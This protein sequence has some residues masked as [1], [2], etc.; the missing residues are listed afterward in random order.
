MLFRSAPVHLTSCRS[1]LW[2][3]SILSCSSSQERITRW[4]DQCEGDVGEVRTSVAEALPPR[5]NY[6]FGTR[7]VLNR[8]RSGVGRCGVDMVRWGF[9]GCDGCECCE[10]Q[11]R[12]HFLVCRLNPVLCSQR[13]LV[14][15]TPNAI[16]LANY[17]SGRI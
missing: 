9:G 10:L 7:R 17:W 14:D 4:R 13:D 8:M 1:F 15:V 5:S 16:T 11:T 12:D 3:T 2:S 6:G